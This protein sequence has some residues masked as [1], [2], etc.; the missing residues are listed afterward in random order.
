MPIFVRDPFEL[1]PQLVPHTRTSRLL[2][3]MCNT[4]RSSDKQSESVTVQPLAEGYLI[5]V[6]F[7][8]S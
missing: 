3:M 4:K 7:I 8:T 1:L 6:A 5:D 2:K